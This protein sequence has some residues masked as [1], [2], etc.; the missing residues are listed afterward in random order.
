MSETTFLLQ[1]ASFEIKALRQRNA[2]MS[3]RLEMFDAINAM[4][5]TRVAEKSQG[6]TRDVLFDIEKHLQENP[7]ATPK[8]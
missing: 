6:M 2:I 1:E 4:L 5:H 3:A 8:Q 7:L